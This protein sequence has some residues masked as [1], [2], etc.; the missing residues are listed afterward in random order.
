[1]EQAVEAVDAKRTTAAAFIVDSLGLGG[2]ERQ[3]V[4][5]F[6]GLPVDRFRVAMAYL[7]QEE[8]LL[9]QADPLRGPVWCARFGKGW[10]SAGL[11]RLAAWVSRTQP[12]VLVCVNAYPLFYG[13][14][15]RWL[16]GQRCSV[17]EVYHG[18]EVPPRERRRMRS[19]YRPFFNHSDRIVYVSEAQR[20]HWEKYG[21]RRD[22][23]LVIH[24]GVCTE[25]FRDSYSSEEKIALRRRLGFAPG[26][27][28]VG[29]CA[30]LRPEKRHEDLVDAIASLKCQGIPAKGLM[31]GDGPRRTAIEGKI[32]GM[33]LSRDVVVTGFQ[34]D[35]RPFVGACDVMAIVSMSETFSMAALESMAMGKPM[36]MSEVGG[37]GELIRHGD[38]GFLFP[39]G[40]VDALADAL[41]TLAD[42]KLR[43][44][45]GA[46]ARAIVENSFQ[47]ETML[48]KYARMFD[49]FCQ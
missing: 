28:V 35:V 1:M 6:N 24:N 45:M 22:K 43:I 34:V 31:I 26:D 37:A 29:I 30:A 32:A 17:V 11:A 40:D 48:E 23:G 2:A 4:E 49:A 7:K 19:V 18:T 16:S 46:S 14:L 39:A 3:T 38:N 12:D 8:H 25:Y 21:L 15:A 41:R 5:L 44:Q 13:H 27:Y 42:P 20:R 9:P 33:G 10:D 36:V 47:L